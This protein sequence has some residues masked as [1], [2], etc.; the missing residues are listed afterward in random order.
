MNRYIKSAD[1]LNTLKQ[2]AYETALNQHDLYVADVFEDIAKNRLDT[3]VD[4]IPTADVVEVKQGK[5]TEKQV[6]HAEEAKEAV[7]EWQSCRCSICGHYNT[8][9]NMY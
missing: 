4:L 9:P 7:E 1:A 6:I 8:Q 3:W 2:L 5:W